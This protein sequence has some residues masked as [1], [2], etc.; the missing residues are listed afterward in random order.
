MI[1]G[2]RKAWLDRFRAYDQ[3]F[4]QGVMRIWQ[5]AIS[6][7]S[8]DPEEDEITAALVIRLRRDPTTRGLFQY[9]DFQYPPVRLTAAGQVVGHRLK[10]DLAAV[11]DQ[12]GSRYIAYECKKL[13]VRRADGRRRSEAG[14]Y[15]EDGMMRF[16]TGD[17]ARDLPVGCM[18]GYVMDGDLSWAWAQVRTTMKSQTSILGLQGSPSPARSVGF[19]RRF[20]TQHKR[21]SRSLEMR[22]ALLPFSTAP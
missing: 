3:K 1:E 20:V 16:V 10:I 9:Y 5:A 8:D 12:D 13:N 21:N 11:V 17:Y 7:L 2:D 6:G 19:I 18:L 4:L 22:H 14:T 15:I